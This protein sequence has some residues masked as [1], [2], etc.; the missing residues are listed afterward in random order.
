MY[1]YM[2]TYLATCSVTDA[3]RAVDNL[4]LDLATSR[5]RLVSTIDRLSNA[6]SISSLRS[7]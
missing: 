7:V 6:L 2:Y 1:M 4:F 5:P 3:E